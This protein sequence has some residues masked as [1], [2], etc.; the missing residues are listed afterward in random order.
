MKQLIYKFF[1]FSKQKQGQLLFSMTVY[2]TMS[3]P[4]TGELKENSLYRMYYTAHFNSALSIR[5]S[6]Y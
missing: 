1:S 5:F 6:I 2:P 3:V 4:K